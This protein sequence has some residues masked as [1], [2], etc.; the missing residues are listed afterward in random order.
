MS[1]LYKV[2]SSFMITDAGRGRGQGVFTLEK[3]M[4]MHQISSQYIKS[5]DLLVARKTTWGRVRQI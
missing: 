2:S 3:R 1:N 4:S 5:C